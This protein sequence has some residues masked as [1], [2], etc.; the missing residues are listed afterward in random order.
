LALVVIGGGAV[1]LLSRWP[2][3]RDVVVKALEEKFSSMVEVKAFHGT[4]LPPGCVA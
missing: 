1:L 3:A 2:F 4:Y